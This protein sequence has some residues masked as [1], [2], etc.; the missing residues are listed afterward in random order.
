MKSCGNKYAERCNENNVLK[1]VS[2]N[3]TFKLY[4]NPVF[5]ILINAIRF[6]ADFMLYGKSSIFQNQMLV[7]NKQISV[8]MS[9]YNSFDYTSNRRLFDT[10]LFYYF[11]SSHGGLIVFMFFM[12]SSSNKVG[13]SPFSD[14]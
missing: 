5:M 6:S 14:F 3:C 7:K 11:N 9:H 8:V 4:S 10:Q 12:V 1:V 13:A 2:T